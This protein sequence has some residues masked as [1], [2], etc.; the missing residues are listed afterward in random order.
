MNACI[1]IEKHHF[2]RAFKPICTLDSDIAG[3][4]DVVD[5]YSN[6]PLKR[7]AASTRAPVPGPAT[8]TPRPRSAALQTLVTQNAGVGKI[9]P[10]QG[11][12]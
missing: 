7:P 9:D 1:R 2:V 12:P 10:L 8:P 11:L 6:R 3:K 4:A 5:T